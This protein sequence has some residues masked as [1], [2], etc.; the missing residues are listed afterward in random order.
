M[1][2]TLLA[3]SMLTFLLVGCG[4][5]EHAKPS[6]HGE[7]GYGTE[8]GPTHWEDF[9]KTCG[10]GIHQSPINIIPGWFDLT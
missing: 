4:G 2:K 8:N 7:W 1:K 10:K 9:S 6:G 5:S 3:L